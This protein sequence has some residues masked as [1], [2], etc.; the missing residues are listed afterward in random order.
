MSQN[1]SI[2]KNSLLELNSETHT[3][4][5][6]LEFQ[7]GDNRLRALITSAKFLTVAL[8]MFTL[9]ACACSGD[10]Q[11]TSPL[12]KSGDAGTG[13]ESLTAAGCM[14]TGCSNNLCTEK[15]EPIV[16]TC[17]WRE[18]YACYKTARCEKQQ[19][20]KCGWTESNELTACLKAAST[21]EQ[22]NLLNVK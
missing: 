18:E 10:P 6:L 16:S 21:Q 3:L 4:K 13:T 22:E 20:G 19:D 9:A 2:I 5:L 1:I 14:R 17:Q 12:V 11:T 15:G 8:S 7:S